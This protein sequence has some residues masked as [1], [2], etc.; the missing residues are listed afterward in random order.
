M[1]DVI[2]KSA[3]DRHRNTRTRGLCW[4]AALAWLL[5]HSTTVHAHAGPQVRDVRPEGDQHDQVL[6]TNRGII[7]RISSSS[8]WSL[9][10][11]EALSVSTVEIPGVAELPNGDLLAATVHGL[12]LSTDRGCS[13]QPV[14]PFAE[15][16]LPSLAQHPMQRE[17]VYVTSYGE[18][19]SAL[20]VSDDSGAHWQSLLHVDDTEYLRYILISRDQPQHLYVRSLGF[21]NGSSFVYEVLHSADGGQNWQ[22]YPVSVTQMETDFV[23]LGVS[24]TDPSLVFAKAEASDPAQPER[25]L[26]SRDAGASFT[27]ALKARVITSVEWSHDGATVWVGADEGLWRSTDAGQNFQR[28]G[29]AEFVSCLKERGGALLVCGYYNG[30]SAGRPG[31]GISHDGGATFE[32][33][34]LLQDV[35]EPLA[36]TPDKPTAGTCA[37]LW[38]DWQREILGVVNPVADAGTQPATPD[39][40]ID[41]GMGT[42]AADAMPPPDAG[43]LVP[44]VQPAT[45][46]DSAQP[47]PDTDAN[48]RAGREP[49]GCSCRA[50]GRGV[51]S[52][53]A[54]AWFA[55]AGLCLCVARRNSKRRRR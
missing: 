20:S 9:M 48:F 6:I 34:M 41:A 8:P 24:P 51:R 31:I 3:G 37:Q 27:E 35:T 1:S 39:A 15:L 29:P 52:T 22:R 10:C 28:V 46:V 12:R 42:A 45:A 47:Q 49:P 11:N 26:I 55:A 53:S 44:D 25:L 54:P 4:M 2:R 18:G 23:L 5:A 13:W 36:C 40:S 38:I 16:T 19:Q 50:L 21:G 14:E 43:T 17:R 33:W 7:Q 30:V 32:R